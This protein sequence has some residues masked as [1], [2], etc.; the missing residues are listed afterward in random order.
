VAVLERQPDA[1]TALDRVAHRIASLAIKSVRWQ[2]VIRLTAP[3]L[4]AHA[5]RWE[6][7]G[8]LRA[9]RRQV[10]AAPEIAWKLCI[11]W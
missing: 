5:C 4:L 6:S 2:G 8:S 7:T 3:M 11:A 10:R 1:E 9:V